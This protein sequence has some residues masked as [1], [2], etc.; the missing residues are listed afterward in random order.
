VSGVAPPPILP[1]RIDFNGED[2]TREVIFREAGSV[3]VRGTVRWADG[4]GVPDIEIR[5]YVL[6]PGWKSGAAELASVRTDSK[7][8]YVL[9]LPAPAK[10][11]IISVRGF[12]R[13]PDGREF[14]VK[15][16]KRGAEERQLT[17]TLLTG[18]V[19]DADWVVDGGDAGGGGT[20]AGDGGARKPAAR[21]TP[22]RPDIVIAEHVLLWEKEIV[23][24][25]EVIKRFRLMRPLGPI[26]PTFHTTAGASHEWQ[27]WHDRVMALYADFFAPAGVSF[28]SISQR[29]SRR[30]DAIRSAA[31]LRPD[32][33]RA[34]NGRVL[35]PDGAPASG[36]QV[37]VLPTKNVGDI[38]LK[39]T[40]LHRPPEEQWVPTGED[41]RFTVYPKED[42]YLLAVLHPSGC[43]VRRGPAKADTSTVRLNRWA[44]VTLSSTG[45]ADESVSLTARPSGIDGEGF[46]FNVL[47]ADPK[48][49]PVDVIVPAGE[50]VV[51]RL[52][53]MGKGAFKVLSNETFEMEPG[54]QRTLALEPPTD[55]ERKRA[56]E[57]HRRHLRRIGGED[58]GS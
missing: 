7:G 23:T 52:L 40:G 15:P 17:F 35:T 14:P 26:R 43:V 29:G 51:H 6:P 31:D 49:K 32:P 37:V 5:S 8:R 12:A 22:P 54:E 16:V 30:L 46:R 27:I 20:E 13:A 3:T 45:V 4:S 42:E 57:E 58:D 48:R 2:K 38:L 18:D 21:P 10:G 34:R 33:A 41:G 25:D 44:T 24:W 11:V 53:N 39:G 1:Q 50:I 55:A 47:V 56:E 19:D 9:R 28:G 36:A